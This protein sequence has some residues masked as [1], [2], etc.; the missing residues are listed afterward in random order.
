MA[1]IRLAVPGHLIRPPGRGEPEPGGVRDQAEAA[2]L[3]RAGSARRRE[4]PVSGGHQ[5]VTT[6]RTKP[7]VA[8]L[9]TR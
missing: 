3:V 8:G 4:P 2:P 6:G 1:C 5:A 7:Q 9:S